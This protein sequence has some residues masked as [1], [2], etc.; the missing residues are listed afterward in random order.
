MTEE[1]QPQPV[2]PVEVPPALVEIA[3]APSAA[4]AAKEAEIKAAAERR[5]VLI[6]WLEKLNEAL[7]SMGNA[8]LMSRPPQ[9]EEGQYFWEQTGFVAE[10][11]KFYCRFGN[12]L[13]Q[14]IGDDDGQGFYPSEGSKFIW[15][16]EFAIV[17]VI[18]FVGAFKVQKKADKDIVDDEKNPARLTDHERDNMIEAMQDITEE[19]EAFLKAE[20]DEAIKEHR[21]R[22]EDTIQLASLKCPKLDHRLQLLAIQNPELNS[23]KNQI[24]LAKADIKS[25]AGACI[26]YMRMKLCDDDQRRHFASNEL[27]PGTDGQNVTQVTLIDSLLARLNPLIPEEGKEFDDKAIAA[28]LDGAGVVYPPLGEVLKPYVGTADVLGAAKTAVEFLGQEKTRLVK[29]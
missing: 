17:K 23:G 14:P 27:V 4:D 24:D 8:I 11:G 21:E 3:Q 26:E 12:R 15:M 20:T 29:G 1:A 28:I 6:N 13:Y 18:P 5:V 25:L 16:H 2:T 19:F 7:K 22:L 9:K 10:K